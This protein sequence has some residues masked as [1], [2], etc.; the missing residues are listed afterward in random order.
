MTSYRVLAYYLKHAHVHGWRRGLST[1]TCVY[2]SFANSINPIKSLSIKT[3]S[4]TNWQVANQ[5]WVKMYKTLCQKQQKNISLSPKIVFHVVSSLISKSDKQIINRN[6][7]ATWDWVTSTPQK[8]EPL[9]P[10]SPFAAAAAA[11]IL[12]MIVCHG[13]VILNFVSDVK[14]HQF[15][16]CFSCLSYQSINS[17]SRALIDPIAIL[18]ALMAL[19]RAIFPYIVKHRRTLSNNKTFWWR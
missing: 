14:H 13:V 10:K 5:N 18:K 11:A 8:H 15:G 4:N 3:S 9:L 12:F 7:Q 6:R 2:V 16:Y 19:C 1:S 17:K